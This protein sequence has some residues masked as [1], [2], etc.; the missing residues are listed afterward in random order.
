MKDLLVILNPRRIEECMSAFRSLSIDKLWVRNMT[1]HEIRH[2]WPEILEASADYGRL[3]IQSDDGIVRPYAL[4]E[5]QRLLNVGH[6]VVTGYSNLSAV[7]FRVNLTKSPLGRSLGPA[8][9]ELYTLAEV[10]EYPF[11]EL[12][13]YLAGMCL[14]GMSH[15]MWQRFPFLTHFDEPPGNASDYVLSCQLYDAGIEIV[16]A[17]DAFVWHC[18][19]I[20]NQADTDPRKRSYIGSEPPSLDLE[21]V[22]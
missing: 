1:E 19:E 5:I 9:Y 18:K 16:A 12:R 7:D 21:C 15:A 10:M 3:I 17:R 6:P 13:S 8:A 11:P 14:T 20:W 4:A 2:R 22:K